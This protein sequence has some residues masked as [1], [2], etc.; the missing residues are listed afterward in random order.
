M[1]KGNR[2][3]GWVLVVLGCGLLSAGCGSSTTKA[4]NKTPHYGPEPTLDQ[5]K[6]GWN[7][8]KPGANTMCARGQP[9]EF[10]VRP[11]KVNKVIVEFQGGGACWDYLSCTPGAHIFVDHMRI[12]PAMSDESVATGLLDHSDP[13][14]PF[15]DW[16]HVYVPYCTGDVHWGDADHEYKFMSTAYTV[17][18]H[19]ADNVKAVLSA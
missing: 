16:T 4:S 7:T 6:Q 5:L 19:G 8:I 13:R 18:H 10:F 1:A 9:W 14:N 12:P 15:R 11:G 17:H 2:V 3:F